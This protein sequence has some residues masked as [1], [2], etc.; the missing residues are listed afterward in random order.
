MNNLNEELEPLSLPMSSQ[1]AMDPTLAD[2]VAEHPLLALAAAAAVGVGVGALVAGMSQR[3]RSPV[4]VTTGEAAQGYQELRAQLARLVERV[5][6]ALPTDT[7]K[8]TSADLGQHLG[9][10]AHKAS[11]VAQG[12]LNGAAATGRS[13]IRTAADHPVLTSLLIGALGTAITAYAR[14]SQDPAAASQP[15]SQDRDG[16]PSDEQPLEASVAAEPRA[17]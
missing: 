4:G 13:A 9:R 15:E 8:Q 7:I 14:A 16:E 17:T 5:S 6:A 1:S 3:R 10:M 11:D 2:V 12:S